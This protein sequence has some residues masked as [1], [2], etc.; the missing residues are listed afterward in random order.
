[1]TYIDFYRVIDDAGE[2]KHVCMGSRVRTIA[3]FQLTRGVASEQIWP[4]KAGGTFGA[5]MR[6]AVM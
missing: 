3:I 4:N 2:W 1:M 6:R 5:S